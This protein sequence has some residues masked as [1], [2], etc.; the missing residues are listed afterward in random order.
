MPPA[1]EFFPFVLLS[2]AFLLLWV[3]D[4]RNVLLRHAW[5]ILLGIACASAVYLKQM[6]GV[7]LLIVLLVAALAW[8]AGNTKLQKHWRWIAGLLF[9]CSALALG[10]HIMP[11][12]ESLLVINKTTL[13]PAASPYSLY[14]NIDKTL[15]AL[16]ILGLWYQRPASLLSWRTT[17]LTLLWML[18]LV[19]GAVIVLSLLV[20]YI[21]FEPKIIDG[22][23][24]W[25]WANLLFTCTA[26]E[27]LFRGLLQH[28]LTKHLINVFAGKWIAIT[29]AALLFGLAHIGGGWLYVAIASVAGFGYGVVYQLTGRIEA[30]I[31]CHFGLNLTHILFFTYPALMAK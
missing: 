21:Q 17:G 12:F 29:V 14:F 1:I 13:T 24:L 25:M 20:N 5:R 7:A 30:S 2:I 3:R 28:Q 6:Q 23:W 15:I 11:G 27:A 26:E 8:C 9:I 31:I 4:H 16:F 19:I 22:L 18:P 10:L